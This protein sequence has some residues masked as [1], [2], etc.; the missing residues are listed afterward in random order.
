MKLF[1]FILFVA[2]QT[3]STEFYRKLLDKE[4]VLE[5]PGMTEFE[6]SPQHLNLV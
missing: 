2:D 4:P 1:Q 5:V 6:L 3:R